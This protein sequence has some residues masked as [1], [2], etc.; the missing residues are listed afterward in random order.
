MQTSKF[1]R[2]HWPKEWQQGMIKTKNTMGVMTTTLAPASQAFVEQSRLADQ[3]LLDIGAAYGIATYPALENGATVTA[4]DMHHDHL[5]ILR[6]G[7]PDTYQQQLHTVQ[8]RFPADFNFAN[9]RFTGIHISMMLHFLNAEDIVSG[10]EKCYAWLKP[11][12]KLYIVVVTPYVPNLATLG[13]RF[14]ERVANNEKWP[15]V[16]HLDNQKDI[17][18]EWAEHLPPFIHV[19][20]KETLTETIEKAGFTVDKCDY[21][22]FEN[23]PDNLTTENNGFVSLVARKTCE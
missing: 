1:N 10:L 11:G 19:F 5:K 3:H 18:P 23:I 4:C 7:V 2:E 16:F 14:D 12:G 9:N 8:G 22:T 15:G 6:Q 13:P 17:D 20:T 21:F